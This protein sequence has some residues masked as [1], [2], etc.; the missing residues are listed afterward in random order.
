MNPLAVFQCPVCRAVPPEGDPAGTGLCRL[1]LAR[2][3]PG[4][5]PDP[6]G[7]CR[8]CRQTL[9][10]EQEYCVDCARQN[11]SFTSLVGI[12]PYRTASGELL[13]AFKGQTRPE[14]ALFWARLAHARLD[15]PGPLVPVPPHPRHLRERGWDPVDSLCRELSRLSGNPVWRTLRRRPTASQ[16]SLGR[17]DRKTNAKA[18]YTLAGKAKALHGLPLVWLVDDVVTTGSTVEACARLLREAGVGE[19]RVVCF[20]LH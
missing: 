19:V 4:E 5:A 18:S 7:A 9:L 3:F 16:K 12:V 13:R 8:L 17:E 15:A 20:C 6:A 1:C 14:L 2:I 11:W 10:G